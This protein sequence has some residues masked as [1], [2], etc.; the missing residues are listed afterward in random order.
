MVYKY[1]LNALLAT[2]H[3]LFALMSIFPDKEYSVANLM[4]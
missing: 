1:F 3:N 2:Q 4:T